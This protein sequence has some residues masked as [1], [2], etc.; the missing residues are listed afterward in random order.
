MADG[1][2]SVLD[3]LDVG[4]HVINGH[5]GGQGRRVKQWYAPLRERSASGKR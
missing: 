3:A 1:R 2:S 5:F 4:E